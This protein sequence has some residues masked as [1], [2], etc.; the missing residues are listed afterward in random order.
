L[1]ISH[2]DDGEAVGAQVRGGHPAYILRIHGGHAR[3]VVLEIVIREGEDREIRE[4]CGELLCIAS[5]FLD[6]RAA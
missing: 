2:H 5:G 4:S 1:G 6:T 3:A